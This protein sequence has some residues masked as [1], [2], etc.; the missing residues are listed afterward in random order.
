MFAHINFSK[1]GQAIQQLLKINS[2]NRTTAKNNKTN[3]CFPTHEWYVRNH[4]LGA[5][6]LWRITTSL[7][8]ITTDSSGHI[9]HCKI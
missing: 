2:K 4:C 6:D 7:S 8:I 3:M 5:S 1:L 9:G